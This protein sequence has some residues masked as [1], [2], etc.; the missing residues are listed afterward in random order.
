MAKGRRLTTS[1]S[2]QLLGGYG[3]SNGYGSSSTDASELRE[4]DIWAVVDDGADL[5]EENTSQGGSHFP[6]SPPAA[7]DDGRRRRVLRGG[8]NC[9]HVGGLSLA[10]QGSANT[11]TSPRI[12]HQYRG[13]GGDS[14]SMA[15]SVAAS[16]QGSGGGHQHVATSAPVN[17]PD[18]SKIYRVDS[19]ESMHDSDDGMDDREGSEIVPPH[20]YLYARSQK[21][22]ATSV[23]EGVGR[24][25]KGRDMRRVRDAVWSRTG[26]DG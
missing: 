21:T 12:V 5:E 16:P 2:E 20:E 7:A 6:W 24:T 4:E 25:L 17:V 22:A 14:M 11:A 10:F 3:Y 1:R 19:V 26:F 18:W 9:G 13:G 15:A 23:F 8:D